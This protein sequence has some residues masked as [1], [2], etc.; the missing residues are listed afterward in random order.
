MSFAKVPLVL[1]MSCCS[2]FGVVGCDPVLDLAGQLA[3]EA[4][5]DG[6]RIVLLDGFS[7]RDGD[8]EGRRLGNDGLKNH[9]I[10]DGAE[11]LLVGAV[12]EQT[13]VAAGHQVAHS[14][15]GRIEDPGLLDGLVDGAK[16]LGSEVFRGNRNHHE[17]GGHH[18]GPA[19]RIQ[20]RRAVDKGEVKLDELVEQIPEDELEHP[21]ILR[22]GCVERSQMLIRGHQH[23]VLEGG[24]DDE[25]LRSGNES[26]IIEQRRDGVVGRELF[27]GAGSEEGLAE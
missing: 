16:P 23:N 7:R 11:S 1:A 6:T 18:R 15:Q 26:A 14:A 5:G 25:A 24:R 2:L 17:V 13:A 9:V 27:D 19:T 8:F 12:N 20:I 4:G 10:V 21:T 3:G 22:A